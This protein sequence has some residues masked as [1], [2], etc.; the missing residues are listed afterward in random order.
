MF[1]FVEELLEPPTHAKN[2]CLRWRTNLGHLSAGSA[3]LRCSHRRACERTRVL[4]QCDPHADQNEQYHQC[5][6]NSY[7]ACSHR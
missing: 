4:P 2:A 1:D 6:T 3:G 5:P 7:I